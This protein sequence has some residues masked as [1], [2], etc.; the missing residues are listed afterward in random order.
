MTTS[1]Q[2]EIRTLPQSNQDSRG[3]NTD[4]TH[5]RVLPPV[6]PVAMKVALDGNRIVV[7]AVVDENILIA[8]N[9]DFVAQDVYRRRKNW[10]GKVMRPPIEAAS[11]SLSRE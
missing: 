7:S 4:G 1:P 5:P 9:R 2:F 8:L 11:L 6:D 3:A 10:L